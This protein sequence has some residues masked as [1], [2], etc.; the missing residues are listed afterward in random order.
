MAAGIRKEDEEKKEDKEEQA[1]EEQ[2]R[3]NSYE[4]VNLVNIRITYYINVMQI[5]ILL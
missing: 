4:I 3:A 5:I 1:E 2:R